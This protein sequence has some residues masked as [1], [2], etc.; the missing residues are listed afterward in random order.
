MDFTEEEKKMKTVQPIREIKVLNNLKH[1]LLK[2][3]FRDYFLFHLGC[4]SGLRVSDLLRLRVCDVQD[5]DYIILKEKKTGKNKRF[6]LNDSVKFEIT[7]YTHGMEPADYLFTSSRVQSS[8]K[9]ITRDT[10][11][12]ALNK[13]ALQLGI[14]EIGT[15]TMRKTFGYHFYQKTKDVAILMQLFNHSAPSVTLKYIGIDQDIMDDAV[16][17]FC[18]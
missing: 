16:D 15:H 18:L 5:R 11:Y 6:K 8:D 13:V 14:E 1:A 12:K 7:R 9:P 10:A 2:Q 3:S 17:D 4:N